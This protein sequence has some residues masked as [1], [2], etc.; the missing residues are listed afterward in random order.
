MLYLLIG[1]SLADISESGGDAKDYKD[2]L[3]FDFDII[4]DV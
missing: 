2:D 3:I 1:Q 4:N